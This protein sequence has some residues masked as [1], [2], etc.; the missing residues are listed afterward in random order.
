MFFRRVAAS[1]AGAI[2]LVITA[3]PVIAQDYH[4]VQ[5]GP[6][7]EARAIS[8]DGGACPAATIDGKS[9]AMVVR[10]EPDRHYPIR[11]CSLPIPPRSKTATVAGEQPQC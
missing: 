6:G 7:L 8:S 10:A 4:W 1:C 5:F 11:V 2:R 3:A 9:I